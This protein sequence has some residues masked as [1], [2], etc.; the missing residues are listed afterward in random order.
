MAGLPRSFVEIAKK[1]VDGR[2]HEVHIALP[3]K[4]VAYDATKNLADVQV[5]IQ[6][7]VWDDDNNRTYEDVGTLPGVPVI[8]PRAG[9]FKMTLPMQVGDT[10][11]LVFNSDAIGEWRTSNQSSQPADS[12]RLSIGWPCFIP[13][14][15][16]DITQVSGSD[17]ASSMAI[18]G[19]DGGEQ[20][21][22]DGAQIQIG[23]GAS[24]P[25]AKGDVNDLN[26]AAL[27]LLMTACGAFATAVSTYATAIEGVADP[28]PPHTPT[29]TLGSAATTFN[30]AVTT[31]ASAVQATQCLVA[32]VK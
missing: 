4:V 5:M 15:C 21:R 12:S 1:I 14:F 9:G 29:T 28:S 23:A 3:G 19:K 6:Q 32:K 11:L 17:P 31:F 30:T 13:G 24:N 25:A 26:F 10:G 22:T 7:S 20:I 16:A 8:W 27:E 2:L 18:F